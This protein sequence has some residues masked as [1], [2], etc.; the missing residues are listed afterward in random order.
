MC[1]GNLGVVGS[2]EFNDSHQEHNEDRQ[3]DSEFNRDGTAF[4]WFNQ[5]SWP[6]RDL[7][8]SRRNRKHKSG[9][10]ASINFAT[11]PPDKF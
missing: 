9:R 2:A 1:Q 11:Q 10:V 8:K 4:R 7:I 3:Q 6:S 5:L